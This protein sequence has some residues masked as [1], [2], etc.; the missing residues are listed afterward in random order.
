MGRQR[1]WTRRATPVTYA[2]KAPF[3]NR[4]QGHLAEGLTRENLE[5][6]FVGLNS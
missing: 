5:R 3:E 1:A 6:I 2:H 4:L